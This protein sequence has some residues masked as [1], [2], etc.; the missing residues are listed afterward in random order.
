MLDQRRFARGQPPPI[1]VALP[2]DPRIKNLVVKPHA[3]GTYDTLNAKSRGEDTDTDDN[4]TLHT[5]SRDEDQ[6]PKAS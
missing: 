3:L 1:P 4:N 6:A 2:D 5:E